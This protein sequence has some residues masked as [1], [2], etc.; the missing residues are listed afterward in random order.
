MTIFVY[1]SILALVL[2][3]RALLI[4]RRRKLERFD[5]VIGVLA[6]FIALIGI[7]PVF[8]IEAVDVQKPVI[9]ALTIIIAIAISL[10]AFFYRRLKGEIVRK[11]IGK[12]CRITNYRVQ[13]YLRR[14]D[15]PTKDV[16]NL[17]RKEI[18]FVSV[19]HEYLAPDDEEIIYHTITSRNLTV[20]VFVLDPNADL[21]YQER[22]FGTKLEPIIRK[23]LEDLDKLKSKLGRHGE[24]LIV[25]TYHKPD[26]NYSLILVD[27]VKENGKIIDNAFM[28]VEE[29][30][31]ESMP[32]SRPSQVIFRKDYPD[33][34][35][36]YYSKFEDVRASIRKPTGSPIIT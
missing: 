16:I 15:I 20:K 13:Q 28:K 8:H 18:L 10:L 11:K 35:D 3:I 22:V 23:S 29:H 31:P 30:P 33:G 7:L 1:L 34:Y 6:L 19:T 36:E 9:G 12:P 5:R 27:H 24:N 14:E 2:L 21:S 32:Y 26:F 4:S 17:A 25:E